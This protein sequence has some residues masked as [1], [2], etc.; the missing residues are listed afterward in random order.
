MEFGDNLQYLMISELKTDDTPQLFLW[1]Q[2]H[3]TSDGE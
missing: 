2:I 3:I 1:V